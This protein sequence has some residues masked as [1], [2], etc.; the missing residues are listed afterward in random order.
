MKELSIEEKARRFDEVLAMAKECITY[1]P[2]DAVNKYML[3]MFPELKES[4]DERIRR[5]ITS[6]L[7]NAYW[8]SNRDRFNELVA[9]LEKQCENHIVNNNEMVKNVEAIKEEGVIMKANA[10]EKI[11]LTKN[12]LGELRDGWDA[13]PSE[14]FTNI[15]YTRTDAFIEKAINW[16]KKQDEMI[17][18]SFQEDFLERFQKYMKGE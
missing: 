7:R 13:L 2:D 16:L 17:G 11:Y 6:I 4:E 14:T 18:V 8:T 10:P 1:I 5:E 3:N 9:W 12:L 15:E